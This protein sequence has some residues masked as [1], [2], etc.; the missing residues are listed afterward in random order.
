MAEVPAGLCVFFVAGKSQPKRHQGDLGGV[1]E[2]AAVHL[3]K[4]AENAH[5]ER[6]NHGNHRILM[7]IDE[8]EMFPGKNP[9]MD[10]QLKLD[11]CSLSS[12]IVRKPLYTFTHF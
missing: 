9:E 8:S 7:N 2:R 12:D 5:R 3:W 4:K 10:F 6:E 1:R 11:A